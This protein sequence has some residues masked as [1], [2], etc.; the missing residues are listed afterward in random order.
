MLYHNR[1]PDPAK[2]MAAKIACRF[3]EE[4]SKIAPSPTSPFISFQEVPLCSAHSHWFVCSLS[5]R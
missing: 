4:W 1:E 3:G 2:N 5:L